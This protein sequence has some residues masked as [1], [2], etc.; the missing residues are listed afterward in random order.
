MR[1]DSVIIFIILIILV[2]MAYTLKFTDA[3]YVTSQIDNR[4]YL[5]RDL[6]DKQ[7]ASNMLSNIRNNLIQLVDNMHKNRNTK[8]HTKYKKY[9]NR[10]KNRMKYA[11]ISES[12]EDSIYTS[13]SVNKGDEVVFCVRSRNKHNQLHDLNLVM[14]V[15][16]HELAH[17]GCPEYGHTPLFK[18]IFAF[19]TKQAIKLKLYTKINFNLNPKEYCGLRITDSI[20]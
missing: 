12:S 19:I 3:V 10:M 18:K 14:Y 5:V 16:L 20:V 7:D 4:E 9:I 13:Y 11:D 17:I 1:R 2:F 6:E 15:A 8:N